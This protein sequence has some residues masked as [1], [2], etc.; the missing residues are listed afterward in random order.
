[1]QNKLDKTVLQKYNN[2]RRFLLTLDEAQLHLLID[3]LDEN[4]C[5]QVTQTQVDSAY[6][7]IDERMREQLKAEARL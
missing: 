1:M 4:N 6:D 5:L 2:T 7:A 3:A